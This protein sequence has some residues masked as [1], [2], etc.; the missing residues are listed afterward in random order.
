MLGGDVKLKYW[1]SPVAYLRG[2]GRGA[3]TWSREDAGW[4]D[5]AAAYSK[6]DVKKNGGYLYADYNFKTRYNLGASYERFQDPDV[7]TVWN[8]SV[9]AFAG[10]ALLEET[11]AFR[12]DWNRLTPGTPD[13]A[14]DVA[15]GGRTPSPS[16]SSTRW[17]PHKAH[18]F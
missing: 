10:L 4:D 5:V 6:T 13:R 16:A 15:R 3:V 18:Q 14:P 11:T 7:R 8:T 1:T 2:A 17:G 9:G 12:L